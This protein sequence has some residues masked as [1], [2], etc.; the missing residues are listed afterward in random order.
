MLLLQNHKR[1]QS[2]QKQTV[3]FEWLSVS[4][5][6]LKYKYEWGRIC[7][8]FWCNPSHLDEM[9]AVNDSANHRYP[10]S[11]HSYQTRPVTWWRYKPQGCKTGDRGL[12]LWRHLQPF[13]WRSNLDTGTV[14]RLQN[15]CFS[16][17]RNSGIFPSDFVP[18]KNE[19]FSWEVKPSLAFCAEPWCLPVPHQVFFCA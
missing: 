2:R 18:T 14:S 7:S 13:L 11:W 3:W 9:L 12:S 19:L 5:H 1:N 4:I 8:I 10:Q 6:V 15:W 16:F 17:C